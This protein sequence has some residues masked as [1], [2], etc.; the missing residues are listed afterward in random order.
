MKD[1]L[2]LARAHWQRLRNY[3]DDLGGAQALQLGATLVAI[4]LFVFFSDWL[5]A[6]FLLY[7]ENR[8]PLG[9]VLVPKLLRLTLLACWMLLVLSGMVAALSHC[10]L[11][12]DL[13]LL[14]ALP[15]RSSS[16]FW[17]KHLVAVGGGSWTVLILLLP[18]LLAYGR[19]RG[20]GPYYL[21]Y[22]LAL[23]APFV[24]TAAGLGT[25]VTLVI[26]RWTSAARA[27]W[28]MICA[29]IAACVG[30]GLAMRLLQVRRVP[31]LASVAGID[32]LIGVD[33]SWTDYLPGTW[34]ALG[35][36]AFAEGARGDAWFYLLLLAA[37]ALAVHLPAL[38]LVGD[39][40]TYYRGWERSQEGSAGSR[41]TARRLGRGA[42]ERFFA[43]APADV[44]A[45]LAKDLRLWTRDALQWA[46]FGA[47][48]ALV[49][50]YVTNTRNL[51]LDA[52]YPLWN[53]VLIVANVAM[54]GVALATFALRFLFPYV[55]MEGDAVW[56]TWMSPMTVGRFLAVKM[57]AGLF[58]LLAIGHAVMHL[59]N[60]SLGVESEARWMCHALVTCMA[61]GLA[62]LCIGLGALFPRFDLRRA[63]EVASSGGGL[64]A[65]LLALLFVF[66]MVVTTVGALRDRLSLG[67]GGAYAAVGL[68]WGYVMAA[69]AASAV[70]A[71]VPALA[72]W[73]HLGRVDV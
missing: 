28:A 6:M 24:L 26:T 60:A 17:S 68:L 41:R 18:M 19:S 46:Q 16:I 66:G 43:W 72:G 30:I 42:G 2:V 13:P 9:P 59:A 52:D 48:L 70:L 56:V 40:Q 47:L 4:L 65:M 57:L 71:V 58:C 51:P 25:L 49:V 22:M 1:T 67:A 12:R 54:T 50:V 44:C 8:P 64:L 55:S 15:V 27:R 35:L 39:G 73:R 53:N 5:L 10:Y 7:L 45:M 31:V 20:L 32:R 36:A 14:F 63:V 29:G 3:S 62:G 34:L 69:A 33:A 38:W 11:A 23:L 61:V 37:T 21:L